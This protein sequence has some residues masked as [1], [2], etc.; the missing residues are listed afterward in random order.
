MKIVWI[1]IAIVCTIALGSLVACPYDLHGSS[2]CSSATQ[3]GRTIGFYLV[4]P[5]LWFG[6]VISDAISTDPYAGESFTAYVFG[7]LLW[8]AMIFGAILYLA[9]AIA[10]RKSTE[11]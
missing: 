7:I 9:K 5:G 11:A 2:T 6:S 4:A 8:L 10:R 3:A 1:L